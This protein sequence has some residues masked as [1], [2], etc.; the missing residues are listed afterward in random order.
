MKTAFVSCL[1]LALVPCAAVRADFQT[2]QLA[3]LLLGVKDRPTISAADIAIDPLTQ[4]VFV[5]DPLGSRVL[6]YSSVAAM[7][8]NA[9]PEAYIGQPDEF[10]TAPRLSK[11]GMQRPRGVTVD[12]S[13]R[14]WVADSGHHR[15]LRFNNASS[16]AT[17]AAASGLLGQPNYSTMTSGTS[18]NR[19]DGP[20]DLEVD[21]AGRLWVVDTGNNRVLRW[22]NA[23]ALAS[24]AFA[25]GV[26]GQAT[27]AG[28]G[29]NTTASSL[30]GPQFLA[31]EHSGSSL[32]RLW[33]S[34]TTNS[35]V[36]AF[37]FP[38]TKANGAAADRVL[39]HAD[40]TTFPAADPPTAASLDQPQG[41]A[42]Q[43]ADLWVADTGNRRVLRYANAGTKPNGG[44]ADA[45]LGQFNFTEQALGS[46]VDH[47][48]GPWAV[49]VAGARLWISDVGTDRLVRHEN[50][51][52]KTGLAPA[53]GTVAMAPAAA[54]T[55]LREITGTAIDPA[56]GK[57]FVADLQKNRV[58]RYGSVQALQTGSLPEAVLGQPNFD[59][60]DGGTTASKLRQPGGIHVDAL[61]NLWVAD[62]GNNRVLRFA[63]AGTLANGAGAAQVFGQSTFT[64]STAATSST[65]M[66]APAAICT[67]TGFVPPF[68]TIIQRLWVADTDNGRVLRFET[69]L[70]SANGAAASGVLGQSTFTSSTATLSSTGMS[71]PSGLA[72]EPNGRLWVADRAFKRVLRFD[73][74]GTK[75]NGA[76]AN[77]VLLQVNFSGSGYDRTPGQLAVSPQGRLF[78]PIVNENRVLWFNSAGTMSNGSLH[79]GVLG[80][81]NLV[82]TDYGDSFQ[83]LTRPTSAVLDP[84][85][86]R[87]WVSDSIL[88]KRYTPPIES[89]ITTYG[90]TPQRNSALTI[91]AKGSEIY[92]IR[93]STDLVNWDTIEATHTVPAN[94]GWQITSWTSAV[95]S[96]GP[97]KF[98]RLQVP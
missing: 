8:S 5:C 94:I 9:L 77:G 74:A 89:Q 98:Y 87:L 88:V 53:D 64:A 17:G 68:A 52:A 66:K 83:G 62:T 40:F 97:K 37:N 45:V 55:D 72:A 10:S 90:L 28:S 65:G 16:L 93:S 7:Q 13:G 36:L 21:A 18:E 81:P 76:A 47:L 20:G 82:S 2:G 4:K 44:T 1:I 58:V 46:A 38:A 11:T 80:Q 35:R 39:G 26:L 29:P 24:D 96:S 6:R 85:S 30:Y 48:A 41:M 19:L 70:N 73:T 3:D 59:V 14:L 15:I 86:G 71:E 84:G 32:V 95:P 25:A 31:L 49:A 67:E 91:L 63:G 57:L 56:T 54:G 23:A 43:G 69:P 75:A 34:D 50:A 42:I 61:G 51:A 60:T 22:D 27:F 92:Q 33:V 78:V 12:A 79:D